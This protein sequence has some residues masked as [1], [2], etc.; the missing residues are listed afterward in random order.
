MSTGT[1]DIG[2]IGLA[3]M[4]S[5]LALNIND[6]GYSLAAY[7]RSPQ[8]LK[9]FME[10]AKGRDVGGFET[11][12]GFCKALKAPRKIV[13]MVKAGSPVDAVIDQCLPYLEKGDILIDGGNSYF[14]D[15]ERRTK[16]LEA[17]GFRF[18]GTGV[19]GGEEGARR[20]PSMMPGGSREAWEEIKEIFQAVAAKAPDG[21]PCCQ[22]MGTGGAGHYVKMVHNGIE[23]GDMQL[24][25]ET[26]AFMKNVL[27]MSAEEQAVVWDKWNQGELSSYLIDITARILKH[28]DPETGQALVDMILDTAGQ[29]GTGKWTSQSGLD[30]GTPIPTIAEAVFAR[31]L[32]AVKEERVAASKILKGPAAKFDHDKKAALEDLR[33]ALYMSKICSYAQGFQLMQYA[34]KEH[35]WDL[36]FGSIA[37]VW[38]AGCIIRAQFLQHIKDAFQ[39]DP[40]TVNLLLVP[41][42]KEVVDRSQAA[43]RWTVMK[44]VEHGVAMPCMSSA[45]SYYDGYRSAVLPANLLQAQRDFFGAHTYERTDQPRGKFFH[46]QWLGEDETAP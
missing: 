31:C 38:R 37:L 11:I 20:G 6:K 25:C 28:K 16:S 41:Y 7:N 24:I 43:L 17:Q 23:Y 18:I 35:S 39:T 36:D 14:P 2:L 33:L 29:K 1:Y 9:E 21:S 44:A 5:N 4:G 3:V 8:P 30:L 42:F 27:L 45:I 15:T 26:Y 40:N 13:I 34:S 19:S 22:F 12:E 10:L 32:S 46:T